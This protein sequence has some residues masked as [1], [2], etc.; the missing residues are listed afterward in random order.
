[1][2]QDRT[3]GEWHKSR[4]TVKRRLHCAPSRKQETRYCTG[5]K[6]KLGNKLT[7]DNTCIVILVEGRKKTSLRGWEWKYG[8]NWHTTQRHLHCAS[9]Q[10]WSE[11]QTDSAA[12]ASS[13]KSEITCFWTLVLTSCTASQ[14]QVWPSVGYAIYK[15]VVPSFAWI[16]PSSS[17]HFYA[18]LLLLLL[19]RITPTYK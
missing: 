18:F 6:T 2:R 13:F 7:L 9:R 1:M 14:L 19:R 3:A 4:L 11:R 17:H 16:T 10:Y 15:R 8:R 5:M 12:H